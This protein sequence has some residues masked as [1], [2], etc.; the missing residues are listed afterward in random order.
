MEPMKRKRARELAFINIFQYSFQDDMSEILE[1]FFEKYADCGDQE[2]YIRDVCELVVTHK[3]E[4]DALIEKYLVGWK[5]DRV[6]AA[7]L[8]VMRL[9]ICEMLY[10][11]DIPIVISI[12]EAVWLAERYE[13][14]KAIPFINGVLG[15]LQK[16]LEGK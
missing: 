12:T 10:R 7:V 9:A 2:A 13:D 6:S 5:I 1:Q 3:S 15:S 8:A 4:I 16:D 11:E 14:E